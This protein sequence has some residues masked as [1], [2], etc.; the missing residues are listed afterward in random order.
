MATTGTPNESWGLSRT[1]SEL[2]CYGDCAG[3]APVPMM[4]NC[5]KYILLMMYIYVICWEGVTID[6]Y[7]VSWFFY[8]LTKNSDVYTVVVTVPST[9]GQYCYLEWKGAVVQGTAITV[10]LALCLDKQ[11]RIQ[12]TSRRTMTTSY[13]WMVGVT[14]T[15]SQHKKNL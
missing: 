6:G 3:I 14:R 9:A 8:C 12:G 1:L 15:R 7:G 10:C 11:S 13:S 4:Y 2:S 5:K